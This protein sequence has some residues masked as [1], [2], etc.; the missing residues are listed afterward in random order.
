MT[1]LHIC[2][3]LKHHT[4]VG[5][6]IEHV[7]TSLDAYASECRA[8]SVPTA[9]PLGLRSIFRASTLVSISLVCVRLL[10]CHVGFQSALRLEAVASTFRNDLG[11]E[12]GLELTDHE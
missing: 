1:N 4:S 9:G 6:T 10:N 7:V 8:C 3:L 5:H 2:L 12:V 11:H